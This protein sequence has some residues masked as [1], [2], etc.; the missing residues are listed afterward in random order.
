[1]TAEEHS[2]TFIS[3]SEQVDKK[4]II[5]WSLKQWHCKMKGRHITFL[6]RLTTAFLHRD[7]RSST[8]LRSGFADACS[9]HTRAL[10]TIAINQNFTLKISQ[11]TTSYT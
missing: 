11:N 6:S 3:A 1:M 7:I 4:L 10:L 2:G 8:S 9:S 5:Y